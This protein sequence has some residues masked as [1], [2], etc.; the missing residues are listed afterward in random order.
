MVYLFVLQVILQPLFLE[1]SELGAQSYLSC[2]MGFVY[3]EVK[4]TALWTARG[5]RL[6]YSPVLYENSTILLHVWW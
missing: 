4:W 6:L 5:F 1:K 3:C 2:C